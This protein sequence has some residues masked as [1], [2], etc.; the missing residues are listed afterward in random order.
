MAFNLV[1]KKGKRAVNHQIQLDSNNL[2]FQT[3]QAKIEQ[4]KL[5]AKQER[6][7]LIDR[8]LKLQQSDSSN[9]SDCEP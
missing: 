1:T 9:E 6:A 4:T 2:I 8:T 5:E 7:I 3:A